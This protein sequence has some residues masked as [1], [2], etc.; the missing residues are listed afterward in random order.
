MKTVSIL[1]IGLMGMPMAK[2]AFDAGLNCV[3][4]IAQQRNA[5]PWLIRVLIHAVI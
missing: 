1:G 3:Y 4:G 5:F 2:T